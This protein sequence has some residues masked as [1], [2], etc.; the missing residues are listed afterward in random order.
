MWATMATSKSHQRRVLSAL[1]SNIAKTE[2]LVG[3]HKDWLD[4]GTLGAQQKEI[5]KIGLEQNK[6]AV[7][8]YKDLLKQFSEMD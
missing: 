8:M 4:S 1:K 3:S 2:R 5:V 7:R 6:R